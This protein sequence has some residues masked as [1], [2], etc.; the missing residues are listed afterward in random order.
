MTKRDKR[1][2]K[3]ELKAMKAADDAKLKPAVNKDI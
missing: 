2:V 1:I 3:K